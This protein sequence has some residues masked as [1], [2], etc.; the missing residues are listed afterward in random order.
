MLEHF[1]DDHVVVNCQYPH[2][3]T[4]CFQEA[5]GGRGAP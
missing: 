3:T 2:R 4:P 1:E 5:D